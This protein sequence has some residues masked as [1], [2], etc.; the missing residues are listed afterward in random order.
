MQ[1]VVTPDC[2]RGTTLILAGF[3]V[4]GILL[5][6]PAIMQ[7]AAAYLWV[8]PTHFLAKLRYTLQGSTLEVLISK[9]GGAD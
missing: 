6:I 9:K 5:I 4:V 7:T 1:E 2:R 8:V 3:L